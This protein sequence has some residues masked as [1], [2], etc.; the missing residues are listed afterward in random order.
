MAREIGNVTPQ[1]LHK[2]L[3]DL[4]YLQTKYEDK[5]AIYYPTEKGEKI[6]IA[7]EV[8][9]SKNEIYQV[10]VYSEKAEK[11]ITPEEKAYN[12]CFFPIL[13]S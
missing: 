8:R 7:I 5:K 1:E 3:L 10:N 6:G 11:I 4:G 9:K 12:K 2:K 13:Y